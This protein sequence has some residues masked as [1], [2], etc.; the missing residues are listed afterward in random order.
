MLHY[1]TKSSLRS[2]WNGIL[3]CFSSGVRHH[4][5]RLT[6]G[7]WNPAMKMPLTKQ[8]I[9]FQVNRSTKQHQ[10]KQEGN[11]YYKLISPNFEHQFV[12]T[13]LPKL[14]LEQ[15]ILPLYIWGKEIKAIQRFAED[16][17]RL[18]KFLGLVPKVWWEKSQD[19][20][21]QMSRGQSRYLQIVVRQTPE[22]I[23]RNEIR[24]L[25]YQLTELLGKK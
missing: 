11:I 22:R 10:Q 23:K 8:W 16:K 19:F 3:P 9:T 1:F 7:L 18:Q 17:A 25:T 20:T 14:E 6:F 15:W 21:V 12:I 2:L 24:C 13:C 5:F 4:L